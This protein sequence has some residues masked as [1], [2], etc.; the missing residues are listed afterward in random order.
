VVVATQS[1][2]AGLY[3]PPVF[4]GLDHWLMIV[5]SENDVIMQA[6]IG[7]RR[8]CWVGCFYSWVPAVR[9]PAILPISL[10]DSSEAIAAS[11]SKYSPKARNSR[12]DSRVPTSL[13]A[14]YS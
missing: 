11:K 12:V 13:T 7:L 3:L 14:N 2:V 8:P 6:E 10:R 1:S 5:R 4:K 9:T